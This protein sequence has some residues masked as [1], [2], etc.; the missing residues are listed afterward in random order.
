MYISMCV[1]INAKMCVYMCV[2]V[3]MCVST[4][5][6]VCLLCSK[7]LN[8]E[9]DFFIHS[10][11]KKYNSKPSLHLCYILFYLGSSSLGH[12]KVGEWTEVGNIKRQNNG[13]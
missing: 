3:C 7:V 6:C 12:W 11:I 8:K 9:C 10:Q 1:Y 4:H 13:E 5:T 2:H